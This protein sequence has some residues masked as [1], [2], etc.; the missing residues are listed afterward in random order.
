M[1][2]LFL[3]LCASLA[4]AA[5]SGDGN[6]EANREETENYDNTTPAVPEDETEIQ[7]DETNMQSDTTGTEYMETDTTAMDRQPTP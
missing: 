1:K 4:I 3:I 5:C 7:Q 2:K 6:R